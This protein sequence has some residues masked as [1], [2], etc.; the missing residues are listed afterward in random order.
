MSFSPVI[1][2]RPDVLTSKR[3][4]D[5]ILRI[6]ECQWAIHWE[7][8]EKA[9]LWWLQQNWK[10]KPTRDWL[11]WGKTRW[12]LQLGLTLFLTAWQIQHILK[13][14]SSRSAVNEGRDLTDWPLTAHTFEN[15]LRGMRTHSVS[16][17]KY[18]LFSQVLWNSMCVLSTLSHQSQKH[19][20]YRN[21]LFTL[22]HDVSF[23]LIQ[24]L[25][26]S[27][28]KSIFEIIF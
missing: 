28:I 5:N 15:Q 16:P 25:K 4:Y 12:V 8:W 7:I 11:K 22:Y 6:S 20:F 9:S 23:P 13:C 18:V 3:L 17:K 26:F 1:H 27:L 2:T 19:A 14:G 21:T 24:V 10:G